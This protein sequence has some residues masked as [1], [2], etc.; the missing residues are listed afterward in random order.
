MKRRPKDLASYIL[1]GLAAVMFAFPLYWIVA[2]SLKSDF[3]MAMIPPTLF[4]HELH[5][6][7]FVSI[8]AR[9]QFPKVFINSIF[10]SLS[11]TVFIL[12]FS[13]MAGYVLSK[14]RLAIN[15]PF[16]GVL[17]S[18][19]I[20]P[21]TVLLIPL[22]HIITS[23]GLGN[24]LWGLILPFSV[25]SFGIIFLKQYIDDIP[26][27]L[28]EAAKIDGAGE[29]YTFFKIIFP[30]TKPALATLATIEFVNNWNSFTVPLVLIKDSAKYT[31]PIK[32]SYVLKSTDVMSWS[33]TLAG[34]VL[35]IIP[36][37]VL[38]L[39]VQKWFVNGI[40]G[41]VKG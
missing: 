13:S 31:L 32:L 8:W 22:Q 3:E 41:G 14:K 9:I 7:N 40:A 25:T 37:Y 4:P 11:A 30:L 5:F 28:V 27:A 10:V 33:S 23:I 2:C 21:P 35:A 39:L 38:F 17:I 18:T 24:N 19:M 29:Y 26:T 6:E 36:I 16:M 34:N 15:K 20:V 1:L 12:L